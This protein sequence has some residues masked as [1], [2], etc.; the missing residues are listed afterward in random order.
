MIHRLSS[1]RRN[2]IPYL[3]LL[4]VLALGAGGGY[5]FAASKNNTI[6]VCADKGT[7]ILHLKTRG[8]RCKRGQTR[9]TWNQRGPEGPQGAQGPTGQPGAPAVSVWANVA[10]AGSVV[11]GQ[12]LSVQR[13]S[14]GTYQVTIT[15]PGC[16]NGSNAPVVTVS[17]TSD[18]GGVA[19]AFPVAWYQGTAGNQQFTIFTG[20]VVGGSFSATDHSFTVMDTCT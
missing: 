2:P 6:T 8:G 12:G 4:L 15:A 19:G 16:A 10:N 20:V 18:P 14:A 11:S 1:A 7:G 13:V 5:A 9:V 17:D 3:A